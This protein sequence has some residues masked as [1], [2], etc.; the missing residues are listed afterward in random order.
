MVIPV[1]L[2]PV[3][4]TARSAKP[5]HLR[6][7]REQ[8]GQL[9]RARAARALGSPT[10][11]GM[12]PDPQPIS[13]MWLSGESWSLSMIKSSLFSCDCA[14]WRERGLSCRARGAARR[15]AK[16]LCLERESTGSL[17]GAG[18]HLVEGVGRGVED[19]RGVHPRLIEEKAVHVVAEV[20]VL[21][22]QA[23]G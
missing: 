16:R 9:G 6:A 21:R 10:K 8:T 22:V 20:V 19:A 3:R 13:R 14:Q 1:T 12:T 11:L 4:C 18:T 7:E 17:K 2:Q 15:R 23:G 5:P